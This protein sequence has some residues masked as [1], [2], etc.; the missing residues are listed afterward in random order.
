MQLDSLLETKGAGEGSG[1][2]GV[3]QSGEKAWEEQGWCG[4]LDPRVSPLPH[5]QL[6]C[7]FA[8]S[9]HPLVQRAE[10]ALEPEVLPLSPNHP[11]S[12][13]WD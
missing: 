3:G 13:G 7:A 9:Q 5:R 1:R 2:G 11:C 12:W 8:G 4:P 6:T 10:C